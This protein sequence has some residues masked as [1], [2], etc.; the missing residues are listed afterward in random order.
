MCSF[1]WQLACFASM[2]DFPAL[3]GVGFA[4][5]IAPRGNYPLSLCP[6]LSR[7]SPSLPLA[8]LLSLDIA[9]PPLSR[10]LSR[11]LSLSLSLFLSL[12]PSLFLPLLKSFSLRQ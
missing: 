11:S 2:S 3:L 4:G 10:S 5:N 7:A 6:P 9:P 8:L 12:S 1:T